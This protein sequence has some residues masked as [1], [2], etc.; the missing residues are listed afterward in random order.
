MS[1]YVI[2]SIIGRA[3]PASTILSVVRGM[4]LYANA[5][6]RTGVLSV[7]SQTD[8]LAWPVCF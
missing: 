3:L 2:P 7:V 1:G 5:A 4:V 8:C 6:T